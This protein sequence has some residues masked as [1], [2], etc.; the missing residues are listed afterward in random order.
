MPRDLWTLPGVR[1]QRPGELKRMQEQFPSDIVSPHF[2]YGKSLRS[3]GTEGVVGTYTDEWGCEWSVAEAG[4]SGEVKNPP[5]AHWEA[6]DGYSPPWELLEGVDLSET[7]SHCE[8]SEGF[9]RAGTHVRPF[10]RMQFLRGTENLLTDILMQTDEFF[11]LRNMIHD[12]NLREMEMWAMTKVD[13]ISF[14]DDW[15]AQG[16]LLIDPELWR[17][18]FKPM[19]REYCEIAKGAGKYVFMHSDGHI[20]AILPDLI[21]IGVDAVNSQLFCMDIEELG[22]T[23][24]GKITFW[25]EICRQRILPFGNVNDVRNA[26]SRVRR[27]LDDGQGGVIAQCEWGVMDPYENIATVFEAWEESLEV[28]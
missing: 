25:G 22:R 1:L 12:F 16:S 11:R 9:V 23:F 7:N 26:V 14:M 2:R 20:R 5:L 15:G 21:E 28:M 6:L 18:L 24:K 8:S 17:E 3:K 4:V 27:A 13:A 10:E 19:Y